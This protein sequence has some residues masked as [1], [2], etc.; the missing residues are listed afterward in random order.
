M[1]EG[2]TLSYAS[3]NA[4]TASARDGE[5]VIVSGAHALTEPIKLTDG[6]SITLRSAGSARLTRAEGYPQSNGKSVPL[7]VDAQESSWVSVASGE[8]MGLFGLLDNPYADDLGLSFKA[9]LTG[10]GSLEALRGR[11]D[12][13]CDG[14][15]TPAKL[16]RY[17]RLS[18]IERQMRYVSENRD[19]IE[20]SV[21]TLSNLGEPNSDRNRTKQNF[22]FDNLDATGYHFNPG[23]V[24][25][26]YLYVQADDPSLLSLTWRQAGRTEN[27]SYTSLGTSQRAQLKNGVNRVVVDL[28]DKQYGHMLFMRNDSTSNGAKVRLEGADSNEADVPTIVGTQLGAH[29][30]Y[31]HDTEHPE[32]FWDFVQEVRAHASQVSAGSAQDMALLQRGDE[33]R[34]RFSIHATALASAYAGIDSLDAARSYIE[35]SNEAIQERLEFFWAFDGFDASEQDGANAVSRMRVH[36]AFT[37]N[38]TSHSSTYATGRYFH[39][40]E[41]TAASF[42][43]GE[44]M[45]GWGMSHE[46]GHVLDNTVLMVNEETNNMYSIAGSGNGEL[47]A[48][49]GEGHAFS[50]S[51]ACHPNILRAESRWNAELQKMAQDLSYTPDWNADG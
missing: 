8:A 34:A 36:T 37:V 16:Q 14:I 42:L 17:E 44:S 7:L 23:Q 50:P 27:S 24:N 41:G 1:R 47:L 35:R 46:Y 13:V 11:L 10:E 51:T 31:L 29:P 5:T 45:Y 22:Q 49:E 2:E 28:R 39:M 20:A 9:A 6:R 43:R 3:A 38:V 15:E 19:A 32:R 18:Y 40:P 26:L 4:A 25:E 33:G 12:A 30:V 48:S 21:L